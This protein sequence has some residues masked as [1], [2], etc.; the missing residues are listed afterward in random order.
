MKKLLPIMLLATS[1]GGCAQ[2]QSFFNSG[3]VPNPL[4]QTRVDT[5]NASWGAALT[6]TNGYTDACRQ[7]LIPSSCR[8][9]VYKLQNAAVPVQK[10]VVAMR[11][12][13]GVTLTG[14]DLYSLASDAI[15][16]YKVLQMQLG[17]K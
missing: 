12:A 15:N 1:L 13:V 2:L 11:G 6:V 14:V 8:T 17:V 9:V 7:R 4:T 3:G 10:R 16:D 5:I